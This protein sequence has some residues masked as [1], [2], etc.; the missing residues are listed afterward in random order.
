MSV[1]RRHVMALLVIIAACK[2]VAKQSDEAQ[3]VTG[4]GTALAT[5][6]PFRQSINAIGTVNARPG[7]YASLAP[8][9]PTR[10]ARIFVVAGQRVARG[11]SLIEF[12]HAPFDAAAQSADAALASA[13][14]NYT[15]A[16]RLAQEG[17]LPQKDADQ[18]AADLAAARSADVTARRAQELATLRAPLSGIVT[19]MTA[20]LGASVDQSQPLVEV[21]DPTALD[22]LFNVS[23]T[24]AARIHAGDTL[25]LSSGEGAAAET[26]GTATV[27]SVAVA[28]DSASRA[29]AVRTRLRHTTRVL[30]IGESVAGRIATGVHADA[31]TV[32]VEALVPD[33]EA[34][35]VFVVDSAGMAHARAVVV[36]GRSETRAEILQGLQAGERV[37]TTGAYGVTDSAKIQLD[38]Q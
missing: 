8:P 33:G 31:I 32:P 1:R 35:R 29:V 37:V 36:G 17:I 28:V 34:F 23:A 2:G 24:E 4:V 5:R 38:H 16:A 27:V 30:R 12:E 20:V 19:R 22:I 18:A 6:E 11:D 9:G 25:S 3:G 13:E 15:R 26:L 10:V 14:H 7:R 21:A